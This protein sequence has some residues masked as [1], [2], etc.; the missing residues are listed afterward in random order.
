M[1][2]SLFNNDGTSQDSSS[3]F[4]DSLS[5]DVFFHLGYNARVGIAGQVLHFDMKLFSNAGL[6]T[7]TL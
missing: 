5:V 2:T 6:A 3:G 4:S 7:W 1:R